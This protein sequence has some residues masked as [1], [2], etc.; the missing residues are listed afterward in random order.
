MRQTPRQAL[1]LVYDIDILHLFPPPFSVT[2]QELF[3]FFL[4][5]EFRKYSYR[6][7]N[8]FSSFDLDH[9]HVHYHD[10]P[11]PP[12]CFSR[13][14]WNLTRR[15]ASH[16]CFMHGAVLRACLIYTRLLMKKSYMHTYSQHDARERD[17]DVTCTETLLDHFSLQLR[18][19]PPLLIIINWKPFDF[20]AI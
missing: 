12:P 11:P 8:C 15:T 14:H 18:I 5:V 16:F 19:L 10:P 17:R 4:R 1:R 2:F 7:N 3:S 13:A 6:P 9:F 20:I